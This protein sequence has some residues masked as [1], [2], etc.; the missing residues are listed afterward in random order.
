MMG[1]VVNQHGGFCVV[2][3]APV[4]IFIDLLFG[5]FSAMFVPMLMKYYSDCQ[6]YG[7]TY[8]QIF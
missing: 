2:V 4:I 5:V 1:K 8:M 3:C 7:S 6:Y